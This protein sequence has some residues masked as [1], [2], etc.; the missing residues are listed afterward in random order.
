M[1]CN[2]Q[3]CRG[4]EPATDVRC[5]RELERLQAEVWADVDAY[6]TAQIA[7]CEDRHAS[8]HWQNTLARTY[9]RRCLRDG[10]GMSEQGCIE[11]VE[12]GY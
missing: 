8:H 4:D 11:F 3:K 7:Y 6:L 5:E 2:C 10:I 9:V 12:R 1:T